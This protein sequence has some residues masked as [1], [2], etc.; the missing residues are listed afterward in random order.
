MIP[1]PGFWF[2]AYI[3]LFGICLLPIFF[4]VFIYSKYLI[5]VKMVTFL[6]KTNSSIVSLVSNVI[7]MTREGKLTLSKNRYCNFNDVW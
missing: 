5:S 2:Q 6:N 7:K 4:E 1:N 3:N